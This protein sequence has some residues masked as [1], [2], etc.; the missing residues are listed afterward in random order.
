ME[1]HGPVYFDAASFFDNLP[2]NED[3]CDTLKTRPIPAATLVDKLKEAFGQA[4]LDGAKSIRDRRYQQSRL[5]LWTVGY[6]LEMHRV[7]AAR[8]KWRLTKGWMDKETKKETEY[9]FVAARSA[10]AYLP[11]NGSIQIPGASCDTTLKFARLLSN[12]MIC[13]MVLDIMIENIVY[14]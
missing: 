12:E 14:E 1:E 10:F 7:F 6:W 9:M 4:L 8:K 2:P 11:W 13:D 5:P 3:P